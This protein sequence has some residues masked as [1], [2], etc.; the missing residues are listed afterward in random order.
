[1]EENTFDLKQYWLL[2]KRWAW[3]L[4][5]ALVLGA[6]AGYGASVVQT[7]V[8]QAITKVM[9]TSGGM[10]D[11]SLDIY[12]SVY[13]TQLTQ[14]YLELLQTKTVLAIAAERLG[15]DPKKMMSAAKAIRDTSIIEITADHT[16]PQMATSIADML[17]T[18]LIEQNEKIQ[19]GRYVLM[20]ESLLVQ[21]TQME[22]QIATLQSQ[23]DQTSIKT[24]D[25]Q[26]QWLQDQ[27]S[28]LKQESITLPKEIAAVSYPYSSTP[29]QRND[30]EQK[31]VRLVQVKLLLPLYE[32]S[33]TNLVVYGTQV[34]AAKGTANSQLSLLT[35]TQSLYQQIYVSVLN[36][37]ESV[38][39]ASLQNTPNVVPIVAAV[40]PEEPIRPKPLLY[41]VLAGMVGLMLTTGILILNEYLDNTVK[42][43]EE[44][45][46]L[47]GLSTIGVIAEMQTKAADETGTY[48][49]KQPRSQ[50]SEAFRSLRTNIEFASV[51]KPIKT[52]L[53]TSP[54]P[55]TGKTTIAANLAINFAQKGRRVLLLDA[56]LRRPQVHHV[57]NLKN[58]IGLTDL[59][60]ENSSV[61][62]V[63]HP[64]E[65]SE[66]L[67]VI[68]SGSLPPNPA[69][70]LGSAKMEQVL[71][72]IGKTMDIVVIDSP[73]SILADVQVLAA[74]VDA[75]LLVIKPGK[76][77]K[78]ATK[79]A[80][81][82][83]TRANARIIGLVLNGISRD[84]GEYYS[85]YNY[86][87]Y[88][89]LTPDQTNARGVNGQTD[90]KGQG[91]RKP[92]F[93]RAKL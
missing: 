58:R 66:K 51:N 73:P 10:A 13:G 42:T 2:F 77:Q 3:L 16:N 33:Y 93:R 47:L 63:S 71:A 85:H 19:S 17:V 69:E 53:V 70:L 75:V 7:P 37:L 74:K 14:T 4:I 90:K 87:S 34:D 43:S 48:V 55:G 24:I 27:I 61:K 32:Q 56:D 45:E 39:L 18:V 78:A 82:Q 52:I 72:E 86:Q 11:Q 25:E 21:K 91:N 59:L 64:F 76:T 20:E 65:G 29:E 5:L 38:R 8:Y 49:S 9:V 28:G 41:T 67:T 23:I 60:V 89:Y 50:I 81:E 84:R 57:M 26:K 54:E 15:I 30:R 79:A 1:M 12:S 44:I 92:F 36:Q 88:Q 22:Q 83:L 35:S 62:D 6:A 31:K 68:T 40:V 46:K 80:V